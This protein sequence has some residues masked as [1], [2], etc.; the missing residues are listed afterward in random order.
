M[1]KSISNFIDAYINDNQAAIKENGGNVANYIIADTEAQ[2]QGL[3]EKWIVV[4]FGADTEDRLRVTRRSNFEKMNFCDAYGQY[5]KKVGCYDAG[6]Y[7][8]ENSGSSA[9]SDCASAIREKFN[10]CVS[11]EK[12]AGTWTVIP[13]DEDD[14]F[15]EELISKIESFI[16]SW[17]GENTSHTEILGWTYHDSH[18]FC[19]VV[20]EADFGEPDCVELDEDEQI[21][22][23]L[24]MPETAPY[25]ENFNTSE[26]T[27]NFIFSFDRWATNPWFCTVERK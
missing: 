18:N 17:Q 22:I 19:T 16:E 9:Q 25:M 20:L 6:C 26:E 2:D 21:E 13:S 12:C 4:D 10:V 8:L 1:K 23:L 14:E 24:Q 7:T 5:G 3:L 27:D 15:S 11:L